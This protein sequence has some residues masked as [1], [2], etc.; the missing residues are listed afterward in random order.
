M[1]PTVVAVAE[2]IRNNFPELEQRAFPVMEVIIKKE[3]L[4]RLPLCYVALLS[5]RSD[6]AFLV[7]TPMDL[8]ENMFIEFWLKPEVHTLANG[9]ESPFYAFQDYTIV[10]DK[11]LKVLGDFFNPAGT[12]IKY[13]GLDI[14]CDQFA[15]MLSF[16]IATKW[17]WCPNPDPV[18]CEPQYAPLVDIRTMF[19][20]QGMLDLRMPNSDV[21]DPCAPLRKN[22]PLN[23]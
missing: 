7:Q 1:T 21:C 11:L 5:E 15:L 8:T 3:T 12:R 13:V 20:P 16:K 17:R 2:L 10:R 6:D 9:D 14:T 4:P 18:T 23:R 22:N 19:D